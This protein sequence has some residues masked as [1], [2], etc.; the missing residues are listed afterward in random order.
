VRSYACFLFRIP[1]DYKGVARV[2]YVH[3]RLQLQ[4]RDGGRELTMAVGNLF[5]E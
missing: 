2:T 1:R 5:A 3:G 4:E